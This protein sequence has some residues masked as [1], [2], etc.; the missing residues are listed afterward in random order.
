M[1]LA[2]NYLYG[3]QVLKNIWI[4]YLYLSI[5]INILLH[6]IKSWEDEKLYY[7]I[8]FIY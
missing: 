4:Q 8:I 5:D 7:C 3:I 2:F 1:N 6:V